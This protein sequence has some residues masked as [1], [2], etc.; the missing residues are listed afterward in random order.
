MMGMAGGGAPMDPA[1]MGLAGGGGAAMDPAMAGQA[2]GAPMDPAMMG[3]AGGGGEAPPP[4]PDPAVSGLTEEKV[5]QIIQEEGKGGKSSGKSSKNSQDQ[6]MYQL[7]HLLL[8][9]YNHLGIPL[10][11]DALKTPD[12]LEAEADE[13][14]AEGETPTPESTDQA[15]AEVTEA[16]QTPAEQLGQAVGV[17]PIQPVQPGVPGG[18]LDMNPETQDTMKMGREDAVKKAQEEAINN[19][20]EASPDPKD[21]APSIVEKRPRTEKSAQASDLIQRIGWL[22]NK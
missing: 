18:G 1:M 3:M 7:K 17:D 15:P 8:G 12:E 21:M 22:M 14:D 5:R 10:P 2:G 20:G 4:S 16:P 13:N 11:E 6:L 9:L 19:F